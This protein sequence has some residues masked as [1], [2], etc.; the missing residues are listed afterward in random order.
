MAQRTRTKESISALRMERKRVQGTVRKEL[1]MSRN[2]KC[3]LTSQKTG[4]NYYFKSGTEASY[5]L[6]RSKSYITSSIYHEM[7]IKHK[8]TG[9]YFT[10]HYTKQEHQTNQYKAKEQLC[11]TFKKFCGGCAWSAH[12][13]PVEGWEA[14]P[15]IIKQQWGKEIPSFWIQK[16]S[17][18]ERG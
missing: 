15:T 14:E 4:K 16:C 18:Y 2:N 3:V 6:G 13:E 5:F 7:P 9:E 10:C 11:C 8:D 17:E 12:F 1:P